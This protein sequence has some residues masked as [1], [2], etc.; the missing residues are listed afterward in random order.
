MVNSTTSAYRILLLE[1]EVI[2]AD[3]IARHLERAGHTV[4]A[5]PISFSEA[6]AAYRA[7]RPQL[8]ILDIRI[9]GDRNGVEFAR[10]L[11]Q[12]P[13]PI[14][15]IYLTS[16]TDMRYVNSIKDT[17]PS[18]Y[19]SKPV[20]VG[21]LLAT[22]EVAMHNH[23][24]LNVAAPV[25]QAT[26]VLRDGRHTHRLVVADIAYLQSR[27]VYVHIYQRG[28]DPLM[29]RATLTDLLNQFGSAPFV[30]VHRSFVVNLDHVTRYDREQLQVGGTTIPISRGRRGQVFDR[31]EKHC[32]HKGTPDSM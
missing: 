10:F 27:H 12:Q 8:A 5:S 28:Q 32:Q 14:P 23:R 19:L 26:V 29:L 24:S 20:Q 16:Q 2:I 3:T 22:V 9:K 15:F 25:P 6:V 18:G 1:D 11:R 7:D 31:L 4:V 21:S 13:D 30:Q 17:Y